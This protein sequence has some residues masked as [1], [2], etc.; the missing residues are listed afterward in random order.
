M[1]SA[2]AG[3]PHRGGLDVAAAVGQG[4]PL[5]AVQQDARRHEA[6]L[7]AGDAHGGEG[8]L[9]DG[10][11]RRIV[12]AHHHDVLGNAQMLVF[13]RPHQM[14]GQ[15]VVGADKG[16]GQPGHGLQLVHQPGGLTVG[17][18]VGCHDA[19]LGVQRQVIIAI[20][21]LMLKILKMFK[22]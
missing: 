6:H 21:D 9:G 13:Q 11:F 19:E 4:G 3:A 18:A 14:D 10:G 2:G 22:K 15:I 1:S 7:A 8:R 5:D 20:L 17:G 16:V 12:E